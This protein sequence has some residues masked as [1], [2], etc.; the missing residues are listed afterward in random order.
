M[1]TIQINHNLILREDGKLFN[2]HTG[3]EANLK[4]GK[5]GYYSAHHNGKRY[6]I[7]QLIMK[8]FGPPK[9]RDDYEIDHKDR[10]K[11]NNNISNLRW[12]S[13]RD[14]CNNLDKSLPI[15]KRVCDYENM[16]EYNREHYKDWCNK[17]K[18]HNREYQR[19]Y[20]RKYRAKKKKEG[21]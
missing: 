4:P 6:Y 17:N 7:H 11:L 16:T 8:F 9:P 1:R 5:N 3:E 12:V 15:G 13:H 14:N 2:A 18:E 21:L 20:M 10:N 19:E